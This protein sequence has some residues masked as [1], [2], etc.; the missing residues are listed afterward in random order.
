MTVCA[1]AER[2]AGS[3]FSGTCHLAAQPWLSLPWHWASSGPGD[4]PRASLQEQPGY[5]CDQQR[6]VGELALSI[7]RVIGLMSDR[8]GQRLSCSLPFLDSGGW[9]WDGA[10]SLQWQGDTGEEIRV[11]SEGCSGP[12]SF[13]HSSVS[14]YL[15]STEGNAYS[16]L[17]IWCFAAVLQGRQGDLMNILFIQ[18][19]PPY[20]PCSCRPTFP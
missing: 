13:T 15:K 4:P 6:P 19:R 20:Q 16:A 18:Y 3:A 5:S 2:S 11:G 17:E 9:K 10:A 7:S 12:R 1:T 8:P 14:P